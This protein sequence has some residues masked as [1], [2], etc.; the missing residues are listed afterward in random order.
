MKEVLAMLLKIIV[1]AVIG[2]MKREDT[3][4]D[5]VSPELDTLDGG[6][7]A[8]DLLDRFGGLLDEDADSLR[9]LDAAP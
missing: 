7:S 9:T 3:V 8:R 5:E 4:A 1:D 2:L 6:P